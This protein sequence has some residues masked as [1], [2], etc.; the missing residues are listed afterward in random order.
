MVV[1]SFF[2]SD[3]FFF[4]EESSFIV[5]LVSFSNQIFK[6]EYHSMYL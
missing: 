2:P 4:L 3:F 6:T 5:N 1:E